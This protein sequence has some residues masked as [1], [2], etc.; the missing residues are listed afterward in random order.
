MKLVPKINIYK[1]SFMKSEAKNENN[2]G[3]KIKNFFWAMVYW[4]F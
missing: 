3:N 1:Y 2:S 4:I